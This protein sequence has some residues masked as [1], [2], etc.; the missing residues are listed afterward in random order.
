MHLLNLAG[1]KNHNICMQNISN[2]LGA[3]P[4]QDELGLS[5]ELM[6]KLPPEK[7]WEL[8]L[9]KQKV[10]SDNSSI[11]CLWMAFTVLKS[12]Q[13]NNIEWR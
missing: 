10:K 3:C 9:S 2:V 12:G 1:S 13:S 11:F 6:F 5:R 8:Y 7:R 4:F